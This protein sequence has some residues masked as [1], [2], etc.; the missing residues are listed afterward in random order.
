MIV[1]VGSL[2]SSWIV[3]NLWVIPAVPML[4]AGMIAVLKQPR[5]KLASSLAIAGLGTSLLLSIAAFVHVLANWH[6]GLSTRETLAFNWFD[7]GATH[8]QL[9]WIL[10][11]LSA[12]MLVMVTFVGLLIFIYSTGYMEHDENYTRFFCFLSLFAGWHAWSFDCEQ[13]LAALYV[14]GDCRAH[15]VFAHWILVPEAK[16]C[17]G[18]EES[19]S[20]DAGWRY[21][22]PPGHCVAVFADGYAA[23][24]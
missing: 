22:F 16:C 1:G 13:S 7:L 6:S 20:Y 24:L 14:L 17:C 18:G 19:F 9:G 10:D 11:P 5:K 4:A 2:S 21:F 3:L 8:L 23:L 12:V 15:L